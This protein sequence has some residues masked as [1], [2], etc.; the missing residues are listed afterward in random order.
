MLQGKE[1][2]QFVTDFTWYMRNLL[3]VK[4]SPD[5]GELLDLSRENMNLLL[6]E[7]DMFETETLMRYI[8]IFSDL[9][10]SCGML[11]RKECWWRS[12]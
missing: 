2:G 9:S 12:R 5:S 10:A 11:R 1:M 8:R 6:E 4:S 3:L 7:K